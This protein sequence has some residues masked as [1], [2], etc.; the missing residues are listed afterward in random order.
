MAI[1]TVEFDLSMVNPDTGETIDVPSGADGN[2]VN[3]YLRVDGTGVINGYNGDRAIPFLWDVDADDL[4]NF[5]LTTLRDGA[6]EVTCYSSPDTPDFPVWLSL[7][8]HDG[9]L[10]MY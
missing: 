4:T 2:V 3:M 1:G 8:T 6:F 10:W 5:S 9:L 7:R